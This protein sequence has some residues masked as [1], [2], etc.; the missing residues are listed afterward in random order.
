MY[1]CSGD[2]SLGIATHAQCDDEEAIQ[3]PAK[4]PR[5]LLKSPTSRDGSRYGREL[6]E[7][8]MSEEKTSTERD[9]AENDFDIELEDSDDG[10]PRTD[11]REE[12]VE[13]DEDE[14]VCFAV[15][16]HV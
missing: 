4:T 5:R 7:R 3:T 13:E 8:D 14:V 1:V 6:K 15:L 12:V 2:T 9:V 16:S 10:E 11:V